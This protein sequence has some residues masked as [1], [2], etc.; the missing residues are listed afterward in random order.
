MTDQLVFA[1]GIIVDAIVGPIVGARSLV[2]RA[3]RSRD[4]LVNARD[5][6]SGVGVGGGVRSRRSHGS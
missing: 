6:S 5:N 1:T 3:R 2:C 4:S